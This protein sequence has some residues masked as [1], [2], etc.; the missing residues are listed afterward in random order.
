[1]APG[2]YAA[3]PANHDELTGALARFFRW[4]PDEAAA[5]DAEAL[6]RW[7]ERANRIAEAERG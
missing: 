7:T 2:F 3:F 6:I 4:G 1:M 5:L